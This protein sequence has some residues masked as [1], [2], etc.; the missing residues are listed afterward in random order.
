[1][2]TPCFSSLLSYEDTNTINTPNQSHYYLQF[3][4][5]YFNRQTFVFSVFISYVLINSLM[6]DH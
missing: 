4:L 3:F 6:E 2:L 1:M 5:V